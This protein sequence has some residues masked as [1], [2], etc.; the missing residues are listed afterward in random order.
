MFR[1]HQRRPLAVASGLAAFSALLS[2]SGPLLGHGSGWS[3][4][5]WLAALASGAILGA[6]IGY[7][8]TW[9]ANRLV[10]R[11]SSKIP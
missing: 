7:A 5:H 2:V 6:V 8:V 4:G 3:E 11:N 10:S 9:T 1:L